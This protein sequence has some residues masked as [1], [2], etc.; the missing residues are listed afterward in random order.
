MFVLISGSF[1]DKRGEIRERKKKKEKEKKKERLYAKP[2]YVINNENGSGD[3]LG[4]K[5]LPQ[6]KGTS[7]TSIHI[8]QVKVTYRE[9]R[10]PC[11]A[12]SG[13]RSSGIRNSAY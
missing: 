3:F 10:I 9:N 11:S 6:A 4:S 12:S 7:T 5:P 13:K 8:H 1:A 2:L